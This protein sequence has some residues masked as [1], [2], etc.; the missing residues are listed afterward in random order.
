MIREEWVAVEDTIN[1]IDDHLEIRNCCAEYVCK[2]LNKKNQQIAKLE[3]QLKNA[4]IPKFNFGSL[5]C[6]ISEKLGI[7]VG[8]NTIDKIK[9]V[10]TKERCFS[11]IKIQYKLT[12]NTRYFDEDEL[13][14][15]KEEA[16][17]KLKELK[18]E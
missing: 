4:I 3:E 12:Y 10:G 17:S 13:F 16:E 1:L 2:K 7:V 9:I 6:Y 18:D 11:K 15:T 14:A 8:D 5:V